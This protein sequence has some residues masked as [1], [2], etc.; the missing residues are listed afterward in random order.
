VH[1][2]QAPPLAPQAATVVPGSHVPSVAQQPSQLLA[3]QPCVCVLWHSPD[4]QVCEVRQAWH[5]VPPVPQSTAVSPELH[6]PVESQHPL[7]QLLG[8]HGVDEEHVQR[9]I[10]DTRTSPRLSGVSRFMGAVA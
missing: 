5:D 8:P 9:S 2:W 10:A 1:A 6:C 7:L 4:A 3:P